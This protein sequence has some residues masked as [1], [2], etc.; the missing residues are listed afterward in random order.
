MIPIIDSH[1]DLAWNALSFNRDLTLPVEAIREFEIGMNDEPCRGYATTTLPELRRAGV[2]LCYATLLARGGPAQ[3]RQ[4][5]Y[6]R[7]DLDYASQ[8][9]AYSAAHGQLAYYRLLESQ[10]HIR[11]VLTQEDLSRH[12]SE[13]LSDPGETP[14]GIVLSMEGTDPIV[15]ADQAEVWW[16]QGLRAAGLS[17][18]GQGQYAYGT[19]VDG[20]LSKAGRALLREFERLGIALDVTHLCDASL[21]EALDCF[22]GR[23]LASHHNCRALV[24]HERQ[25]T[26]EQIS[27][28]VRRDAVIGVVLDNWMLHPGW[29][30]GQTSRDVVGLE[31]VADHIDHLCQLA[32]NDRHAAIG[33]DLDGGFGA[34]Q[35]P[36]DLETIADLQKL[37]DILAARNYDTSSIE[38]VFFG[39]WLRFLTEVLPSAEDS[40]GR[41]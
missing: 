16:R 8:S 28:L 10:G 7:T 6:K 21:Q 33:S 5:G 13:W 3:K 30:R 17:H 18:Y 20:P 34:E 36:R 37:A 23:V 9:I 38:A 24:P 12:W 41:I 2:G 32:G 11:F 40:P 31:A 35:S 15:S 39:N 22:G 25:L 27:R 1:L 29:V 26:D 4:S 14:L 19:G